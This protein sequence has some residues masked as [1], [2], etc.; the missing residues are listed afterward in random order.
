MLILLGSL[1][2][3]WVSTVARWG[4]TVGA[5][6]LYL[7]TSISVASVNTKLD[8]KI[9]GI[10]S[11]LWISVM[12]SYLFLS[13]TLGVLFSPTCSLIS[14]NIFSWS[15]FRRHKNK[16]EKLM[17]ALDVSAPAHKRSIQIPSNCFSVVWQRMQS[18]K[19][20]A[21]VS[22]KSTKLTWK[23][24]QIFFFILQFLKV[25]INEISG[26]FCIS[27]FCVLLYGFLYRKW[28]LSLT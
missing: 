9:I 2:E 24:F 1:T 21:P 16:I 12:I 20:N 8:K 27:C 7:S 25:N 17:T 4:I 10:K 18:M 14:L 15:S 11:C 13:S 28:V 5:G 19:W 3:S 6:V 22:F 26:V 23:I